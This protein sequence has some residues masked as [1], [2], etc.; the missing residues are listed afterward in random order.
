[1]KWVEVAPNWRLIDA[2]ELSIAIVLK[3]EDGYS[4]ATVRRIGEDW[5]WHDGHATL[6]EAQ[7]TAMALVALERE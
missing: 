2:D 5:D 6:E 3:L 7:A 1:M 4:C